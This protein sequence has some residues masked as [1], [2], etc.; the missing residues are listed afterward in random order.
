MVVTVFPERNLKIM[1]KWLLC[2]VVLL[3]AVTPAL[4]QEE[5][6][7]F[8]MHSECSQDLTGQTVT[9]YHFGDISGS[10]A[11]ITQPLLAGLEDAMEY[12]NA[13]GGVC[14][15]NIAADNRDT[16]GDLAQTQAHYDY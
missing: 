3:L 1:R 12:F 9:I 11:F 2:V 4:A 5:L 15:A 7:E 13:R 10:Y 14:G 8:I 6:P 16:G